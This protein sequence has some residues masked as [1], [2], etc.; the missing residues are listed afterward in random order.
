MIKLFK[1]FTVIL[2][3]VLLLVNIHLGGQAFADTPLITTVDYAIVYRDAQQEADVI[4][5]LIA[6]DR[7]IQKGERGDFYQIAAYRGMIVGWV[8]KSDLVPVGSLSG[9]KSIK[10]GPIF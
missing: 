8:K 2:I 1:Q 4:A 9:P 5:N 3:Q 7:V 10:A 6:G